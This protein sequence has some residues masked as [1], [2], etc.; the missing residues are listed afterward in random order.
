MEP[1]VDLKAGDCL[2]YSPTGIFGSLIALKTWHPIAHVEVYVGDHGYPM[3]VAS[4]DGQGVNFYPLRT[5]QLAYVLRPTNP[6]DLACGLRY[7]RRMTGT[8]YGW[9]DLLNFVGYKVDRHGIV[10]SPFATEFYR[11]CGWNIFPLDTANQVAPFQFQSLVGNGFEVAWDH[12]W[13]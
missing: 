7:A 10:C 1:V 2:L 12:H 5:K 9:R 6:L 11:A 13:K 4:R 3:S 8:P